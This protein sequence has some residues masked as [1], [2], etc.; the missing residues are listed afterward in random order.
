MENR[1]VERDPVPF[2]YFFFS[3]VAVHVVGNN[4]KRQVRFL[5]LFTFLL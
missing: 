5:F 3:F 1:G 2:S 4:M